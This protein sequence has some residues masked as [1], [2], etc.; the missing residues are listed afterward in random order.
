MDA[1]QLV[2]LDTHVPCAQMLDSPFCSLD[3]NTVFKN[4]QRLVTLRL[5]PL[6]GLERARRIWR[7]E[8]SGPQRRRLPAS[9]SFALGEIGRGGAGVVKD[10]VEPVD[11]GLEV[12]VVP[13]AVAEDEGVRSARARR[14][15]EIF[16][17]RDFDGV[18]REF[19]H[20]LDDEVDAMPRM[21]GAGERVRVV[22]QDVGGS[23]DA[24]DGAILYIELLIAETFF[25]RSV[26]S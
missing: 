7:D 17:A 24:L 18:E 20:Q 3:S 1:V 19:E 25:P 16:E 8:E 22:S 6:V 15:E 2:G 12:E 21:R 13:E 5:D 14:R 26:G 11:G 9:S 10:A 23:V 4:L